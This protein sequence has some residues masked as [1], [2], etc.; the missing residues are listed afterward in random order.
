[1]TMR[2][3][4]ATLV[5]QKKVSK[6]EDGAEITFARINAYLNV[7]HGDGE[8]SRDRLHRITHLHRIQFLYGLTQILMAY[9]PPETKKIRENS[10]ETRIRKYNYK[11]DQR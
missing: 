11:R 5:I 3:Q 8:M 2:R 6:Q 1:M 10:V 9:P 7:L 4:G